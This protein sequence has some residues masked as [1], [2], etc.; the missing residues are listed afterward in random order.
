MDTSKLESNGL[1]RDLV[2]DLEVC[3]D[4]IEGNHE[5]FYKTTKELKSTMNELVK[6]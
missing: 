1:A 3:L 2:T 6:G 5:E 4:G